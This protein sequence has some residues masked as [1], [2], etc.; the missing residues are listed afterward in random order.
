MYYYLNNR[1]FG[2]QTKFDSSTFLLWDV[3]S[4]LQ[5]LAY[6]T[7]Y[8]IDNCL[9][10]C[11][12]QCSK[13]LTPFRW[14]ILWYG[15]S[16]IFLL[17][18]PALVGWFIEKT[19]AWLYFF[20]QSALNLWSMAKRRR[21]NLATNNEIQTPTKSNK[22]SKAS[23]MTSQKTRKPKSK[24]NWYNKNTD[25]QAFQ[26]LNSLNERVEAKDRSLSLEKGR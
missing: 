10:I 16:R 7:D 18:V 2:L 19:H 9:V 11:L 26:L 21:Y 17:A 24:K 25:N 13:R 4:S 14:W 23:N 8:V 20:Q 12:H 22:S 3:V 5:G 15:L 1:Q 6:K